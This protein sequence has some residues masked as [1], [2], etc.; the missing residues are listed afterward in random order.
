MELR[1]LGHEARFC[2][3]PD[4]REWIEGLGFHVTPIGPELR[5]MA[6]AGPPASAS[7]LTPE[8]RRKL[9]E[10]TV[11]AQ[12]E[13][14]SGAAKECDILVAATALQIAARSVTETIG[15]PYVFV[16]YAPVVLPSPHHAPPP[17][18]A[19]PGQPA[20]AAAS[21]GE[22]WAR[23]TERFN[24]L[25]G[26]VLNLHR[27]TLGLSPVSDVRTH[28]FGDPVWLAAD[29]TLGPW[30]DQSDVSVFQSGAWIV[31]D[32]RPLPEELEEFL[33]RGDPPVYFGFGSI[34]APEGLSKAMIASA[35]ALGCRAIV[36][37]G[38]ADLSLTNEADD[39][40]AIGEVN[41]QQ[42]LRR[43]AAAVHHGGAGTTTTA[44]MAGVSQVVVPQVY[45]Q[46]YWAERV[47]QLGIGTAHAAGT[48]SAES[49]TA[50]LEQ[51]LRPEVGRRARVIAAG[52]R[53]DGA[54]IAARRIAEVARS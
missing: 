26:E 6:A 41:L 2:V 3:P 1:S 46:H 37:R 50:A 16:A 21:N 39:C 53:R 11:T 4:F 51:A 14:V 28:I 8:M 49:L 7:P 31:S 20:A 54:E 35:R 33:E 17:L 29:P 27:A 13:T 45:D 10:G 42:L 44:A 22:L 18:P 9:A 48:P 47:R 23:D 43:V 30:P 40:L 52:I 38:W 19:V 15:I 12:F 24:G 32:E 34:R 25:F 36:S 5:K